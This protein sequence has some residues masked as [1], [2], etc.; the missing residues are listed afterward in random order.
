MAA[1]SYKKKEKKGESK[2]Y[3]GGNKKGGTPGLAHARTKRKD[4]TLD[5]SPRVYTYLAIH[6]SLSLSL[7]RAHYPSLC[8]PS[9]HTAARSIFLFH[10]LLRASAARVFIC[11]CFRA[12]LARE[13]ELSPLWPF[14]MPAAKDSRRLLAS[15]S[16]FLFSMCVRY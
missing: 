15:S 4:L 1:R 7:P 5:F 8:A 6:D 16:F 2:D 3:D 14:I 10:S 9:A 13:R 12:S 11:F